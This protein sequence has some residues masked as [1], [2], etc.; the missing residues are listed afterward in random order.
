MG[1]PVVHFE[2]L[3][4]DAKAMQDFYASAFD[5]SMNSVMPSYAMASPGTPKGIDGGIGSTM[6]GGPGHVTFYVEVPDIPA[7]L[8]KIAGLGGS[9]IMPLMEVP[10]GTRIAM[11]ADPEGHAVG[12]V[13]AGTM[14]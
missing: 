13:Q 8:D 4:K 5:W 7:M 1:F 11:F 6:D 12:L 10:G 14:G 3:G 2:V 9:T